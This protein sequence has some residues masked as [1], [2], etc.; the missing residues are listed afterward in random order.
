MTES[1][2]VDAV[3]TPIGKLGGALA[4][5]RPDDLLAETYRAIIRRWFP[6]AKIVADRFHAI[7]LV[8]QHL[9]KLA[10]QLCPQLGWN[11]AWLGLLRTRPTVE[12]G[13]AAPV[14]A[15]HAL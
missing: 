10:R 7:R 15:E 1:F 12:S 11:R 4:G 6:R 9:L 8:G 2:I 5:V 13:D 3:R 14:T